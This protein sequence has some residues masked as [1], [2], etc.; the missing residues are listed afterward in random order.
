MLCLYM[1]SERQHLIS[2]PSS[3]EDFTN[4]IDEKHSLHHQHRQVNTSTAPCNKEISFD[5]FTHAETMIHHR[6]NFKWSVFDNSLVR[7]LRNMASIITSGLPQD[8]RAKKSSVIMFNTTAIATTTATATKTTTLKP[9]I[10]LHSNKN[11][12]NDNKR[13]MVPLKQRHRHECWQPITNGSLS[14]QQQQYN[15]NDNLPLPAWMFTHKHVRDIRSNS[16]GL[17]ILAIKAEM[18][19]HRKLTL[20]QVKKEQKR[21]LPG[22]TD[23]FIPCKKSPLSHQ[24]L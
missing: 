12:N 17:R 23:D 8:P 20:G 7:T 24:W 11:S 10:S 9:I 6:A 14:E 16:D 4:V 2:A 15:K 5:P 13:A 21:Y 22:R 18:V 1:H 19:R 3:C